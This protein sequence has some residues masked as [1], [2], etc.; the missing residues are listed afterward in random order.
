M[1]PEVSC[2]GYVTNGSG[3][4]SVEAKVEAIEN[5]PAPENVTQLSYYHRF[6]AGIAKVLE[7][8]HK[9]LRPLGHDVVL[10]D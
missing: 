5:A 10:E 8:L 2:C 6:L 7:P 1:V 4:K 9:L 3:I